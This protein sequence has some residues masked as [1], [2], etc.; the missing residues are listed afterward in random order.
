MENP[1]AKTV[2]Y[3]GHLWPSYGALGRACNMSG[4]GVKHRLD[5]GQTLPPIVKTPEE[6]KGNP[7]GYMRKWQPKLFTGN[8]S[9]DQKVIMESNNEY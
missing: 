5:K 2:E 9:K 7:S 6:C 8:V 3:G 4:A 1:Q